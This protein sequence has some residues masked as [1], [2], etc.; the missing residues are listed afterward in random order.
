MDSETRTRLRNLID[1]APAEA[2]RD[3][4][5]DHGMFEDDSPMDEVR[6]FCFGAFEQAILEEGA[7]GPCPDV[8]TAAQILGVVL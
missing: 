7:S 8:E 4:A 2:L 6:L 1:A 5:A 3:F